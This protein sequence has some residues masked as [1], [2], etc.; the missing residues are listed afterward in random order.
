MKVRY[1]VLLDQQLQTSRNFHPQA[2]IIEVGSKRYFPSALHKDK[3]GII[4]MMYVEN[5]RHYICTVGCRP[6]QIELKAHYKINGDHYIITNNS[7]IK[8][9][10]FSID[11]KGIYSV[12]YDNYKNC[13]IFLTKVQ[14]IFLSCYF[15]D[16]NRWNHQVCE[17]L[18][19]LQGFNKYGHLI[20]DQGIIPFQYQHEIQSIFPTVLINIVEL[21]IGDTEL[22]LPYYCNHQQE[23]KN[24][25]IDQFPTVLIDK[26]ESYL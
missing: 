18:Y 10:Y 12:I 14:G 4:I 6:R 3:Y 23:R 21:Y 24:I 9:G 7:L 26:I 19:T 15:I 1:S 11:H 16:T 8:L 2:I 20:T 17:K 13:I 5:H 25:L 22:T